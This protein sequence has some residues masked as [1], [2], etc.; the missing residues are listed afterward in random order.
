V[1]LLTTVWIR[2]CRSYVSRLVLKQG[3]SNFS[4]SCAAFILAYRFAGRKAINEDHLFVETSWKFIKKAA[5][6]LLETG[7]HMTQFSIKNQLVSLFIVHLTTRFQCLRLYSVNVGCKPAAS[8]QF[9][10]NPDDSSARAI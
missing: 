6:L 10:L 8:A 3:F 9:L 2:S 5:N 7:S 1:V 4:R